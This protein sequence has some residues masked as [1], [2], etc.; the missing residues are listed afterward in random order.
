M[1]LMR[2]Y[3]AWEAHG[4]GVDVHLLAE[5]TLELL[6]KEYEKKKEQFKSSTKEHIVE[7]YGGEE[8]TVIL[9]PFITQLL[10]FRYSTFNLKKKECF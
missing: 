2:K 6:Q 1:I 5:P 10:E 7:K 9:N 3:L 4:K 8:H